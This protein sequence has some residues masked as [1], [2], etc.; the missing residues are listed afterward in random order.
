MEVYMEALKSI[1]IPQVV[2]ALIGGLLG[3]SISIK[4]ELYG[5]RVS[6]LLAIASLIVTAAISEY[7]TYNFSVSS[8]LLQCGLGVFIGMLGNSLLNAINTQ[9]P[10]FMVNLVDVLSNGIIQVAKELPNLII[11]KLEETFQWLKLFI[12]KDKD[13]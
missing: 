7:L 6:I 4:V 13:E 1:F 11:R 12:R 10:S 8:I 3:A 9:A 2:A 5:W